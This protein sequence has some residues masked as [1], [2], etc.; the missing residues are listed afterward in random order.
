MLHQDFSNDSLGFSKI[1]VGNLFKTL[2]N[3]NRDATREEL[4]SSF[5]QLARVYHPDNNPSPDSAG[6]F[7]QLQ[8]LGCCFETLD[9]AVL[10]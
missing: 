3:V 6:K 5:I 1:R 10:M 8:E 7:Q 9:D 4:K 2:L